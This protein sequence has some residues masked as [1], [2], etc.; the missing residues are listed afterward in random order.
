MANPLINNKILYFIGI[1]SFLFFPQM[2]RGQDNTDAQIAKQYFDQQEFEKS[3]ILYKKLYLQSPEKYYKNYYSNLIALRK[4]N[5]AKEIVLKKNKQNANSV[6][7][8]LDLGY[9]YIKQ[10]DSAQAHKEIS[11]A[12][13]KSAKDASSVA[14]VY[15]FLKPLRQY[16]FIIQLFETAQKKQNNT[17][18]YTNELIQN[19]LI[20]A[21]NKKA[22]NLFVEEI[23]R[24]NDQTFY[25]AI[26]IVQPFV[27][28]NS[29]LLALEKQVYGMLTKEP[30]SLKWNEMALWLS[31]QTRN[32]D[33]AVRISK[34]L[35]KKNNENGSRLLE[36]AEMAKGDRQF[37]IAIDCYDYVIQKKEKASLYHPAF[38]KKSETIIQ[39]LENAP[40]T[41][42][43]AIQKIK[44]DFEDY[45]NENGYTAVTGDCQILY[46][47]FYLKQF[48][49]L[50]TAIHI[51][52]RLLAIGDISKNTRSMAKLDLG[53]YL[54]M[55]GDIWEAA[56]VYGQVGADEK[57][58]PLGEMARFKNAKLFYY[59]GEFELAQELLN[60]LKSATSELIANDALKIS[61]FIQDH[62]D[63]EAQTEAM[64]KVADA[65][66]FFLQNQPQKA[67]ALLDSAKS[68]K[69]SESLVD[70]IWMLEAE[71]FISKKMYAQATQR[72]ESLVTKYPREVL[73][74]KAL[75]LLADLYEKNPDDKE[76]AK[77][78][79]L[80]ILQNFKDS[81]YTTEARKRIRVLRG[82]NTPED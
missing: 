76:K 70:D 60:I 43:I 30:N 41:D 17:Q 71:Y 40:I 24:L 64:N 47:A 55:D 36:L 72:L 22:A 78:T 77:E 6:E 15:D 68:I 46:A 53:D 10:N 7:S 54:I 39:K 1:L 23:K 80:K 18:I 69:A 82:E 44:K 2:L 31:L 13:E 16:Q 12:I 49:K 34:S 4:Y 38:L 8:H 3:E 26:Q 67:F 20:L 27:E 45:F 21:E 25:V 56:L 74:D 50:D 29:F 51:L 62:L 79:Y 11:Q 61:V 35:D 75:Y 58:S 52:K 73:T 81:V 57:D 42:S 37:D 33:D 5:E 66:L 32:Y 9:I 48:N 14:M 28:N 65:E 19:Y 63:D 59:K